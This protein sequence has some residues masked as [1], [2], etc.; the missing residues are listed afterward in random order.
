MRGLGALGRPLVCPSISASICGSKRGDIGGNPSKKI[1]ALS[2]LRR[3][4]SSSMT[5]RI[6][7]ALLGVIPK[8]SSAAASSQPPRHIRFRS[9]GLREED[10]FQASSVLG[11][12]KLVAHDRKL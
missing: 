6:A 4:C 3:A 9:Q 8:L 1:T 7:S 11:L 5:E 12:G 10:R 2:G